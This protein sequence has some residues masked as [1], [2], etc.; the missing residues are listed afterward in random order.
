[1]AVGKVNKERE[2]LRPVLDKAF[3]VEGLNDVSMEE[4][5]RKME[6]AGIC[7]FCGACGDCAS[8]GTGECENTIDLGNRKGKRRMLEGGVGQGRNKMVKAEHARSSLPTLPCALSAVASTLPDLSS[9]PG[10]PFQEQLLDPALQRPNYNM[11]EFGYDQF[12]QP[13]AAFNYQSQEMPF[14]RPI[15]QDPSGSWQDLQGVQSHGIYGANDG[16]GHLDPSQDKSE[17][18]EDSKQP[19]DLTPQQDQELPPLPGFDTNWVS[20]ILSLPFFCY[21]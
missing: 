14:Q 3:I 4:R 16:R 9:Y 19:F 10:Q 12:R 7:W 15:P 18:G 21:I 1:M 13:A 20:S 5:H 6:K 2:D 17:A 8:C 11:K